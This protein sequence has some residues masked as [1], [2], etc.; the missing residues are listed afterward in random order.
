MPGE[1]LDLLSYDL[2]CRFGVVPIRVYKNAESPIDTLV[3][4]FRSER[5]IDL[6]EEDQLRFCLNPHQVEFE[7]IDLSADEFDEQLK[8]LFREYEAWIR[9]C[10]A[11]IK[12]CPLK[13]KELE[14]TEEES[15]RFCHVCKKSVFLVT[16]KEEFEAQK[17]LKHCVAASHCDS[18][19]EPI[20]MGIYMD[21]VD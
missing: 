11:K 21:S 7:E 17:K 9:E 10:G 1:V 19:I 3:F 16:S 2:C 13:W 4:G 20:H 6:D 12:K 5:P 15:R 8:A 14:K 18:V